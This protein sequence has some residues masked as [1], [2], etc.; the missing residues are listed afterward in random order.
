MTSRVC[1]AVLLLI[2]LCSLAAVAQGG[3]VA[4]PPAPA[5][6]VLAATQPAPVLCVAAP[7]EPSLA[8]AAGLGL[9]TPL[10]SAPTV[11]EQQLRQFAT[12][13]SCTGTRCTSLHSCV[14]MHCC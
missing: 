4:A 11:F 1:L 9:I 5:A 14:L 13:S 12:C 7:G 2:G 8:A 6:A 3:P 10:A